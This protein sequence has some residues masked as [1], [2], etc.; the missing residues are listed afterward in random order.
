MSTQ[1]KFDESVFP[2]EGSNQTIDSHEFATSTLKGVPRYPV[3]G[4][5]M[6]VPL[7]LYPAEFQE[8]LDFSPVSSTSSSTSNRSIIQDIPSSPPSSGSSSSQLQDDNMEVD[9]H[10]ND[11]LQSEQL[12]DLRRQIREQ[13]AQME[14]LASLFEEL[15]ENSSSLRSSPET[16]SS[17][18]VDSSAPDLSTLSGVNFVKR[19]QVQTDQVPQSLGVPT[20]IATLDNQRFREVRDPESSH[21][22]GRPVPVEEVYLNASRST[23]SPS[24]SRPTTSNMPSRLPTSDFQITSGYQDAVV[25]NPFGESESTAP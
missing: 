1:V 8:S 3:T 12:Q 7:M 19:R 22:S 20:E 18:H 15:K 10:E 4:A 16:T 17:E 2:L 11:D 9:T 23:M 14:K 5:T 13:S 21:G 25:C 6:S 24:S